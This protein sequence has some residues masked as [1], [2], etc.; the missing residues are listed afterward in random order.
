LSTVRALLPLL[1]AASCKSPPDEQHHMP[2]ADALRGRAAIER[3]GCAACHRIPGVA[4]PEGSTGPSLEGFAEQG[5]IAGRLPNRPDML[6]A[7]VRNAPAV[8]PGSTMP[9]MPL[10]EQEARDVAAYLYASGER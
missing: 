1:L 2:Q 6:A 4:W 9:A 10:T 3:A 5:L 7:F 8:L